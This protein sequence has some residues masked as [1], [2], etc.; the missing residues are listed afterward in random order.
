VGSALPPGTV[1]PVTAA[2]EASAAKVPDKSPAASAPATMP[3]SPV[4]PAGVAEKVNRQPAKGDDRLHSLEAPDRSVE[5]P[6]AERTELPPADLRAPAPTQLAAPEPPRTSK[7]AAVIVALTVAAIVGLSLWYLVQPQ[8]LLV[9]GEADATRIDIAAR[10]DGRVAQRPVSRADNV[11]A[12]QLLVAIDNPELLMK[13]NE[14]VAAKAV[15]LAD[16]ARIQVGTR[17]EVIAERKAAVASADANLTLAQQTYDRIKQITK[18]GYET[19]AKLD[20]ATASLDVATRTLEQAK[21]AYEEA[22]AGYTAE[23]RGVAKAAVDKAEAAIATLQAQVNEMTVKAPIAGQV[24]QV[25]SE[26]GEYVS[27]GVPLLSLVDLSDVWLRFDLR[28]DLVKGLKVGDRFTVKI[29]ALGDKTVAVE[30]RTLA[31]RG[32]YAGWRATRA[33]GDFD[34]RT[35]EVRA[36]P[37]EKI[38]ELRPGMSAYADWNG[39]R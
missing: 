24:Y 9:Q 10:I 32:E 2:A 23:E 3:S 7:M 14:A 26:L 20:E 12:G 36:Y 19:V 35:F 16:L 6:R 1:V 22:V 37:V 38:A 34:L 4:D 33:T 5:I 39:A 29:P 30:V 17:A 31:T 13:L 21:L 27:P 25:G 28:E 18:G 8:P 11:A 15:A